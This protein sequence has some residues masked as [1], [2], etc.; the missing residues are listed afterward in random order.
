MPVVMAF[1]RYQSM[2]A[3]RI[4]FT[5]KEDKQHKEG[6]GLIVLGREGKIVDMDK[7]ILNYM[8]KRFEDV[9]EV[10]IARI[11]EPTSY[12]ILQDQLLRYHGS[13]TSS[14][15]AE[16]PLLAQDFLVQFIKVREMTERL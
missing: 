16:K 4:F 1:N 12:K 15:T 13:K 8:D 14:S 9:A 10:S 3:V 2:G 7:N 6:E 11:M 5:L